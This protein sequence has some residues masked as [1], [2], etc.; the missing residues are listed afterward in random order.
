MTYNNT[1]YHTLDAKNRLF[2]PAKYRELLGEEFIIFKGPEKCLYVY[3]KETFE[4]ISQQFINTPNRMIQRSFFSQAVDVS[5]D[6]Q[7]RVTLSA[8]QVEHAGLTKDA[9][10]AGTGQRIEIWAAES[11]QESTI[12]IEQIADMGTYIF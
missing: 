1:Y 12:T 4:K 7:G 9:V 3:D 8:D 2:I 11:F 5:P 10:I 6:K